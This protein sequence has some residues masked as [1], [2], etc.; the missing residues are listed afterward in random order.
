MEAV[1]TDA[2]FETFAAR[3][4]PSLRRALVAWYGVEVGAEATA[5]AMAVAW[6][7]WAEL[8]AMANPVGYLFRVGQSKSRRYRRRIL[9][10]PTVDPVELPEVDPR[11]PAALARCSPQQRAAVLLVHAHGETLGDAAATLGCSVSSLR[12]HLDRGMRRL[13]RELG[14]PD[15]D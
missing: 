6:E 15:A 5:D 1:T 2:S 3:V 11:L 9:R 12:N 14:G 4:E 13:R 10:L 8:E 7:R